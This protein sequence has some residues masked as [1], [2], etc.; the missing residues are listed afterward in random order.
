MT[1]GAAIHR[2]TVQALHAL[3]KAA[4]EALEPV[5]AGLDVNE[6]ITVAT[7]WLQD[8]TE[9]PDLALLGRGRGVDVEMDR[10][11]LLGKITPVSTAPRQ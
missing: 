5:A 3:R 6:V 7:S 8:V 11:A 4:V 9:D 1:P 2:E 10:P